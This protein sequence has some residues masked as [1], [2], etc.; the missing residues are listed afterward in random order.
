MDNKTKQPQRQENDDE[1]IIEVPRQDLQQMPG[2]PLGAE[3]LQIKIPNFEL[4]LS[5]NTY[6]VDI[7]GD[8]CLKLKKNLSKPIKKNPPPKYLG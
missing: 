6:A 8:I 7:L 2:L 3:T 5:S 4:C 1:D